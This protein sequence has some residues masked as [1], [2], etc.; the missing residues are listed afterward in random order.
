MTKFS[1]WP[2][3]VQVAIL[4]PNVL[5]GYAVTY[6][7][8][9]KSHKAGGGMGLHRR[10]GCCFMLWPTWFQERSKVSPMLGVKRDNRDS[11]HGS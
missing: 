7:W 9:P 8:W 10:I 6:F 5:F 2:D 3:W 4:L 1:E 11:V